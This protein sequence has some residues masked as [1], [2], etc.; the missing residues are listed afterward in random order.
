MF[1]KLVLLLTGVSFIKK[2]MKFILGEKIDMTQVWQEGRKVAVTRVKV[3]PCV[4]TQV[5]TPANDGYEAVQLGFGDKKA[6]NIAKPQLGHLKNLG[7][8]RYL[9]EFRLESPTDLKV[10]DK[11]DATTFAVND[12]VQVTGISKGKGFAGVV[13]RHGFH[14][15]DKTHGNKDQL[16]MPGSIGAGGPAHVF[17]GMRMPGRMGN[18]Q[19]TIKNLQVVEVLPQENILYISAGLPGARHSLVL[20]SGE[21]ELTLANSQPAEAE[22]QPVAIE[23][24]QTEEQVMEA[25]EELVEEIKEETPVEKTKPEEAIAETEENKVQ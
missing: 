3:G 23:E 21:G 10:G 4:V 6:K 22:S 8:F 11:I 5:K 16:R 17:K 2:N 9:K 24:L 25:K 19:V 7:N 12:E 20:I 1:L 14:G 15:Q 13:K 18:D